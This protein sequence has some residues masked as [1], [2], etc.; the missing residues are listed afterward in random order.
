MEEHYRGWEQQGALVQRQMI[1]GAIPSLTWREVQ[2]LVISLAPLAASPASFH[3]GW[4]S[5]SSLV[6]RHCPHT[7]H[8]FLTAARGGQSPPPSLASV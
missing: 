6:H 5:P 1:F 4:G 3:R 2:P 8:V 7:L